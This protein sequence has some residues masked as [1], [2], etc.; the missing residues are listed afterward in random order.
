MCASKRE[1]QSNALLEAMSAG[2]IPIVFKASGVEEVVSDGWNGFIVP[3]PNCTT[4]GM[5]IALA[6]LHQQFGI[7]K[8]VMTSLQAVS[9]AGRSPGVITLDIVDNVIPFIKG[10]EEKSEQEPLKIWGRIQDGK[11]VNATSPTISAQCLRVPVSEE[12]GAIL[13]AFRTHLFDTELF[14]DPFR[15]GSIAQYFFDAQETVSSRDT[16]S[17]EATHQ[18]IEEAQLFLEGCQSCYTRL[19]SRK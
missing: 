17:Q 9:G 10:E 14:F 2:V 7:D 18:L 13:R 6:P 19:I 4:C 11:I 1:G 8:V 16:F 5:A 12:P 15:G 3:I